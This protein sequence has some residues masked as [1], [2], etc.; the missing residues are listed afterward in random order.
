MAVVR[1]EITEFTEWRDELTAL[2]A[3][4]GWNVRWGNSGGGIT[5]LHIEFPSDRVLFGTMVSD[6]PWLEMDFT[7]ADGSMIGEITVD[8]V[9]P[10]P[11]ALAKR[12]DDA[13]EDPTSPAET[14]RAIHRLCEAIR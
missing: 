6:R 3:G 9:R 2:L 11:S 7:D 13:W 5:G 1:Q 14:F 10:W 8:G 4:V 12:S